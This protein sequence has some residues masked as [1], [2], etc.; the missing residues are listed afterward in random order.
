MAF[1]RFIPKNFSALNGPPLLSIWSGGQLGF[2]QAAIETFGLATFQG[3]VLFLD[4]EHYKIGI[5][6]SNDTNEKGFVR[7]SKRISMKTNGISFSGK[8]VLDALGV[9]PYQLFRARLALDDAQ[10]LIIADFS[11]ATRKGETAP[12]K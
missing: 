1:E 3:A 7:F 8:N 9:D 2:N 12:E 4:R 5:H 6:R 10:K 11:G